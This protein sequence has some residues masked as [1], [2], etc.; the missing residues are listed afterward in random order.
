MHSFGST[1]S[2]LRPVTLDFSSQA[3]GV[4][5]VQPSVPL[6]STVSTLIVVVLVPTLALAL[7]SQAPQ[8]DPSSAP[9]SESVPAPASTAD[10]RSEFDFDTVPDFALNARPR[11]DASTPPS[12][13][14]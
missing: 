14:L 6:V 11:P 2:P 4:V 3:I 8:S 7:E 12:S 1:F 10:P 5:I 9:A 13:G